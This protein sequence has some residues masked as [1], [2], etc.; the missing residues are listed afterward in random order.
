MSLFLDIITVAVFV[1]VIYRAFRKGF[2]RSLVELAGYIASFVVAYLLSNPVGQWIDNAFMN[3][4]VTGS[5]TQLATSSGNGNEAFLTKILESVP[6]VATT[7]MSGIGSSLGALG[8]KA[9]ASIVQAISMPLSQLISRTIAF[10]ILLALCLA[11]VKII[12][13]VAGVFGKLPLIGALNSLAGAGIGVIQAIIIMFFISTLISLAVSIMALQNNPPIT[14]S[15][16]NS[17]Q[18]YKYVHNINPLTDMLL[19]K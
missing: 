14:S 17:T 5:I 4:F 12:A 15:T 3:K 2:L 10:F 1:V 9:T 11:A 6:A 16:I 18:I 7:T 13:G 8:A 19:K